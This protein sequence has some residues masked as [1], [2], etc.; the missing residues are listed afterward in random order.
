[1]MSTAVDFGEPLTLVTAPNVAEATSDNFTAARSLVDAGTR[2]DAHEH[3][4]DQLAWMSDG[5]M[6]LRAAGDRWRLR[7]EHLAWIP[8]GLR[9]EMTFDG[10]GELISLYT[11]PALRPAGE[12]WDRPR[13]MR[14]DDL[15]GALLLHLA[16]ASPGAARRIRCRELLTDLIGSSPVHHDVVELPRDSRARAVAATLLENPADARELREWADGLGVSAKTIARAFVADTGSSF[17]EWRIRARLHA[18]AGLLA[19]GH[20]VQ[21]VAGDVGYESASGFIVAFKTRFGETPARYAG[22]L[23]AVASTR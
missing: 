3:H 7:R 23:N 1:M 20:P 15:A 22:R 19:S 6:E 8:A 9:H 17:R 18:A 2:F 5:S 13:M 16:D 14:A 21:R 12:Q 4:E 11:D 10:P